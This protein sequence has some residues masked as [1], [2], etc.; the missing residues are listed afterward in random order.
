MLLIAGACKKNRAD[1]AP[2]LP[3]CGGAKHA[4][5]ICRYGSLLEPLPGS[6]V[7]TTRAFGLP[8]VPVRFSASV[9][10]ILK[11]MLYGRPLVRR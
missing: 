2:S 7:K 3:G 4:V 1:S 10:G 8:S 11:A 6:H 5:L 9:L